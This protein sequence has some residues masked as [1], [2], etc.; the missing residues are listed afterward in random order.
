[1]LPML[2]VRSAHQRTQC[3]YTVRVSPD[4]AKRSDASVKSLVIATKECDLF[5][6]FD[7]AAKIHNQHY[8]N[9]ALY[10]NDI[11]SYV[12]LLGQINE[13]APFRFIVTRGVTE[14]QNRLN[15]TRADRKIPKF[16]GSLSELWW[17]RVFD[18]LPDS[19]LVDRRDDPEPYV[20]FTL[21]LPEETVRD[22][23]GKRFRI[24]DKDY[25]VVDIP[26]GTT[27]EES[28]VHSNP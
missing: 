26:V 11:L 7:S 25:Y 17:K 27:S 21:V 3:S 15:H 8:T 14:E 9:R 6:D 2:W 22:Y 19:R 12:G 5:T 20:I 10:I 1:M 18:K 16:N 24:P 28:S 13:I 4:S 23:L